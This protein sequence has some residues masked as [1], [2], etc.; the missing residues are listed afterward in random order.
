MCVTV[1]AQEIFQKMETDLASCENEK[2]KSKK[3]EEYLREQTVRVTELVEE[4]GQK[5]LKL[6]KRQAGR[7]SKTEKH[8]Q[9]ARR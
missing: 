4:R 2:S 1:H 6:Q 7:V 5:I 3:E 9:R 8:H